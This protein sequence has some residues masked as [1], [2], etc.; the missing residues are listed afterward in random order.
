MVALPE[1]KP[2]S[3]SSMRFVIS[4]F[5][6]RRSAERVVRLILGRRLAACASFWPVSSRYWWNRRIES[7]REVLVL[8]KTIRPRAPRLL[9]E[10]AARHPYDVPE[11]AEIAV[12][13]VHP[14]Y[15]EYL[16]RELAA[17]QFFHEPGGGRRRPPAKRRG[18]R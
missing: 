6:D 12:S 9:A 5:P 15:L 14:P 1:G 18:G 3:R 16:N 17:R 2:G 10:L 4:A 11:V 8:F 7:T 13:R